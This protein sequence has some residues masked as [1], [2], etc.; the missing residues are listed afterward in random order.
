[1]KTNGSLMSNM[2]IMII[3]LDSLSIFKPYF[4]LLLLSLPKVPGGQ[5]EV[6]LWYWVGFGADVSA[7][8][9]R[10]PRARG[11]AGWRKGYRCFPDGGGLSH[12]GR[13][14]TLWGRPRHTGIEEVERRQDCA[15]CGNSPSRRVYFPLQLP[16]PQ[17]MWV[18]VPSSSPSGSLK[19]L[20]S[21][22]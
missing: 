19:N 18:E 1:M 14:Q 15:C 16:S 6:C 20:F 10:E 2:T 12:F 21:Y 13:E 7:A 5:L 9:L 11:R 8:W 17:A 4:F 3:S 22:P